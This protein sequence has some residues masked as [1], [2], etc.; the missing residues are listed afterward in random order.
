MLSG[1]ALFQGQKG[2]SDQLNKIWQLLGTPTKETWPEVVNYPDYSKGLEKN[3]SHAFAKIFGV[4][5]TSQKNIFTPCT[6]Q[7]SPNYKYWVNQSIL[8]IS[9]FLEYDY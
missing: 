3:I 2:P 8:Y 6:Y 9:H 5:K 1:R 4:K 7:A